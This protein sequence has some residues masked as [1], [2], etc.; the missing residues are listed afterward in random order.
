MT[1]QDIMQ[2]GK[3][4]GKKLAN[5]PADYLIWLYDNNKCYGNLRRYIKENYD[6]LLSEID[7]SR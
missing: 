4:K 7:G 1:D 3:N 6:L 5:V 2:F